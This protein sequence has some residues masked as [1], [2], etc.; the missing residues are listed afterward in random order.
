MEKTTEHYIVRRSVLLTQ[1]FSGDKIEKNEMGGACSTYERERRSVYKVL[2]GKPEVKRPPGRP[3]LRWEDNIKMP[4]Q[5]VG[6]GDMDWI[7]LAE[8]G[9][10][11]LA[12]VKA[13]MNIRIP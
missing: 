4:L 7:D 11:W 1:Y 9:D 10:R 2:V 5:E 13:V 3:R 6:R 12:V 8:D